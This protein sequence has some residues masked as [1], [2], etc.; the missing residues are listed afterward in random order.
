MTGLM[1]DHTPDRVRSKSLN[2]C[3]N[4]ALR[5]YHLESG[6]AQRFRYAKILIKYT[7]ILFDKL[8]DCV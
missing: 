4:S 7:I 3:L 5:L 6:R 8:D 2:L 1:E